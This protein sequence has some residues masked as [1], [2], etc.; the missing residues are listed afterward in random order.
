MFSVEIT[1]SWKVHADDLC[2]IKSAPNW[3]NSLVTLEPPLCPTH[4]AFLFMIRAQ[5]I[6]HVLLFTFVSET[7]FLAPCFFCPTTFFF[8]P[9]PSFYHPLLL[10]H[11]S[12]LREKSAMD[13]LVWMWL[14]AVM[15][16]SRSRVLSWILKRQMGVETEWDGNAMQL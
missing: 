16:A 4:S 14:C 3:M 12:R 6:H 10:Y 15:D 11:V 9:P 7:T 13:V 8:P 1:F 2:K 5:S